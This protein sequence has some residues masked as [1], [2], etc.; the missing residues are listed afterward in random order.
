MTTASKAGW[1]VFL[2]GIPLIAFLVFGFFRLDQVFTFRTGEKA[3]KPTGLTAAKRHERS[4]CSDPD[5]LDRYDAA[6]GLAAL[7]PIAGSVVWTM[8]SRRQS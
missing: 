2:F 3:N 5:D 7:F 1:D 8:C 4:M 6:F